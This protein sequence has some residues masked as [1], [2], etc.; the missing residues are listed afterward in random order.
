MEGIN[1]L[2]IAVKTGVATTGMSI[3]DVFKECVKHNVPG[4]PFCDETGHVLGRISMRHAFKS[5]C[6]PQ[7]VVDAAHLLGDD[8]HNI[9]ISDSLLETVLSLPVDDFVLEDMAI[10]SAAS[11]ILKAL[12]I[13]ER[14]NTGY[15]FLID[16]GVYGGIVTRM[17]IAQL[18]LIYR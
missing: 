16:K 10:I 2:D 15:I 13:M 8:L 11:P 4:I 6:I 12:A 14:Y 7:N 5:T 18:M 3:G 9:S 17:G 1:L